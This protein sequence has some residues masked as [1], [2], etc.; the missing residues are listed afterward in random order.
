M[1]TDPRDELTRNFE[2]QRSLTSDLQKY[3]GLIGTLDDTA[4]ED[5][6][7]EHIN[8]LN[9]EM[10]RLKKEEIN[11]LNTLLGTPAKQIPTK[12]DDKP[13]N[14]QT[15]TA[16]S[17][18]PLSSFSPLLDE[19]PTQN[20]HHKPDLPASHDQTQTR[21]LKPAIRLQKPPTFSKG[22]NFTYFADRFKQHVKLGKISTPDLDLYL[23]QLIQC[24]T[25][26]RKL[27]AASRKLDAESKADVDK[28]ITAF[29]NELYPRCEAQALSARLLALRQKP[30]EEMQ[31]FISR[32]EEVASK[33]VY[34][35]PDVMDRFSLQALLGGIT[36][37]KT[38][39]K[40]LQD[41]TA[42]FEE[43][44]KIALKAERIE[45]AIS[46]SANSQNNEEDM[47]VFQVS[48]NKNLALGGER[49]SHFQSIQPQ[50]NPHQSGNQYGNNQGFSHP[51]YNNPGIPRAT[52]R[53]FSN[54]E[55]FKCGELGHIA[56]F[57]RTQLPYSRPPGHNQ[58]NTRGHTRNTNSYQGGQHHSNNH[59]QHGRTQTQ[60]LMAS[61]SWPLNSQGTTQ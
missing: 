39:E 42:T 6:N 59:P 17:K 43:A 10:E 32:I 36:S 40:I 33:A 44:A 15:N 60:N 49:S 47:G 41:D 27:S 4:A 54:I 3:T 20:N 8:G 45:I 24:Q 21:Y 2:Q 13:P 7:R 31:D 18:I 50:Q 22:D 30:N 26:H 14:L 51:R 1:T 58:Y 57:C 5:G 34:E 48:Y 9:E 37:T 19:I 11:L 28:L 35:S 46:G 61:A 56:R 52:R 29:T 25:T 12:S 53:D 23:L 55:C 16:D 38:K